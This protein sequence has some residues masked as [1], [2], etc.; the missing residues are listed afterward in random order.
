MSQGAYNYNKHLLLIAG[1][2]PICDD[3]PNAKYCFNGIAMQRGTVI[4]S[5]LN[6]AKVMCKKDIMVTNGAFVELR[7]YELK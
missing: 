5:T 1:Q 6:I 4:Y 7:L 3:A 2:G